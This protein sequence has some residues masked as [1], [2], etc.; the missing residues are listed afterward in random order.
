MY[1]FVA[2]CFVKTEPNEGRRRREADDAA[3]SSEAA[4]E[5]ARRRRRDEAVAARFGAVPAARFG[6]LVAAQKQK[7]R[8]A[9]AEPKGAESGGGWGGPK[10]EAGEPCAICLGEMEGDDAVKQLPA[11]RH[12]Y[13]ADC[14]DEWLRRSGLCPLCKQPVVASAAAAVAASAVVGSAG[15]GR[16][17]V[18][19]GR[20]LRGGRVA[21]AALVAA[22]PSSSSFSL[23]FL[24]RARPGARPGSGSRIWGGA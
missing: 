18:G 15:S 14:L 7:Q 21:S 3:Y 5:R 4:E 6:D 13:H 22:S 2:G 19:S 23:S 20:S 16:G 17:A 24:P 10:L 8:K 9:D 1:C 11:C 12:C